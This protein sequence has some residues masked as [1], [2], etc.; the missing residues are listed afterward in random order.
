MTDPSLPEKA[1]NFSKTAYDI[2][3]GFVFD[4]T[5]LVPDEVKKARIDI[6]RD[7]NRFDPERHLCKE[8][9]CFLV[10]KVKFSAAQCPL[11]LW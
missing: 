1:A 11:N 9:G 7:C 8:C 2:V 5:L 10:N 4:G 6:C 3:K